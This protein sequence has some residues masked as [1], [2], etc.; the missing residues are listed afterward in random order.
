MTKQIVIVKKTK[1]LGKICAL[2]FRWKIMI[3]M[4]I[5]TFVYTKIMA[6]DD[7]IITS[8]QK[9]ETNDTRQQN[10]TNTLNKKLRF[11][12]KLGLNMATIPTSLKINTA[13]NGHNNS[14]LNTQ[15]L[16]SYYFGLLTEYTSVNPNIKLQAEILYSGNGT[17]HSENNT[18]EIEE[19]LVPLVLKYDLIRNADAALHI[20][21]GVFTGYI[22]KVVGDKNRKDIP[23]YDIASQYKT[24]DSG[25]VVGV[26]YSVT[27]HIIID[28]RFNY[29]FINVSKA[30]AATEQIESEITSFNRFFHFGINYIF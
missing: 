1:A 17:R 16:S 12:A 24:F 14:T 13:F 4:L 2:G 29:G 23:K 11:G 15:Y 25:L 20:Y 18:I 9:I 30:S 28:T 5:S 26:D 10:N 8:S 22:F 27:D 3:V 6:Q 21:G 7:A 19:I